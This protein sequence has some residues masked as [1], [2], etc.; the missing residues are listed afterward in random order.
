MDCDINISELQKQ[1]RMWDMWVTDTDIVAVEFSLSL[2]LNSFAHFMPLWISIS[3]GDSSP[4]FSVPSYSKILTRWSSNNFTTWST[5]PVGG[6]LRPLVPGTL[7]WIVSFSSQ[8]SSTDHLTIWGIYF[9][10][11]DAK[12][13]QY[14]FGDCWVQIINLFWSTTEK[15]SGY[16]DSSPKIRIN[17]F[18]Y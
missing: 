14:R 17:P 5:Y 4:C 7:S 1:Q 15:L 2:S 18:N 12:F 16:P 3:S 10:N 6:F 13:L 8:L 9:E 11:N